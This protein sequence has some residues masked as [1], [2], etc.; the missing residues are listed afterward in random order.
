MVRS[1]PAQTAS[2]SAAFRFPCLQFAVRHLPIRGG[3]PRQRS[4][5]AGQSRTQT[6]AGTSPQALRR[7]RPQAISAGETASRRHTQTGTGTS[8][9]SASGRLLP[10]S[11]RPPPGPSA[12]L[13]EAES[14]ISHSSWPS[15]RAEAPP[16]PDSRATKS[17][18]ERFRRETAISVGS[19]P[20][21]RCSFVQWRHNV[22]NPCRSP[23]PSNIS[24]FKF[25]PGE[26]KVP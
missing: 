26:V 3:S 23:P 11:F 15:F 10:P 8:P 19:H 9:R 25:Q 22:P 14:R 2:I 16:T 6:D 13:P 1:S 20:T 17:S 24:F 21:S 7:I 18:P 12:R 4:A 5:G